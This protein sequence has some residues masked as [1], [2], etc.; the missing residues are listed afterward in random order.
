[1]SD[2]PSGPLAKVGPSASRVLDALLS[3]PAAL[4]RVPSMSSAALHRVVSAVGRADAVEL[5]ALAS[6]EQVREL[7]DLDIWDGDQVDL[8]EALDWI[9]LLAT[10]LPE[11]VTARDLLALDV[12]LMGFVLK[13]HLRI[14]LVQEE[15]DLPDEGEGLLFTPD[16]WFALEILAADSTTVEQITEVVDR[17]YRTDPDNARRLL[18]NLMWELPSELEEWSYHW[19]VGRLQDLGFADPDQ[20]LLIYAYLDP[21]SVRPSEGTADRPPRSD[22][23]PVGDAELMPGAPP[24]LS[25]WSRAVAGAEPPEQQ[26]LANALALL[27]NRALSADRVAPDDLDGARESLEDLHWRLS[28]GL[29]HLSAGELD[30][31][32][33]LLAGVALLRIARVGHSL[34]LDLRR[35]VAPAARAGLL[36]RG[37]G[38][39][40][41]LDPPLD[42]QISSLL[43]SRPRFFDVAS[44][45][46]R[47]FHDVS[48]LA[49]VAAAIEHALRIGQLVPSMNLPSPLPGAVTYGDLFRTALVNHLLDRPMGAVDRPALRRF[50]LAQVEDAALRP[51]VYEAAGRLV[52]DD[53]ANRELAREWTEELRRSVVPLDPDGLDLRFVDG[54]WLDAG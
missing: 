4:R 46:S 24:D 43:G 14:F 8:A 34:A 5:I 12:E 23:E 15:D 40:D 35:R 13:S 11:E 33:P 22:P 19:R 38:R 27:G 3:D 18:Q 10:Q 47:V 50:L 53:D 41:L 29:E 45:A 6:P 1:M 31:A 2:Q 30:R 20:A 54:L 51:A 49:E 28:L 16:G 9:H 48:E 32:R 25:F 42:R 21:A 52:P 39:T 44:G 7:L 37:P 36:G 17:Y 26:R